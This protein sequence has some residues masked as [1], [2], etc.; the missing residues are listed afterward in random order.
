A[1]G[2][3]G[4]A[5][6][7][8][9][10]AR[11]YAMVDADSGGLYRS[12]DR[13]EHWVHASGDTRIWQRGWYFAGVTV[14]PENADVGY[15]CTPNLYRSADGGRTFAPIEG[16][17]TGDDFH[18]LWID[19]RRPERRILG[20]DQGAIVSVDGGRSWSSWYNQPTAQLYHVSTDE[21]FP[22]QVYGSQQ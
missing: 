12:D 6:A 9:E 2:R 1:P 22:Y 14:E 3:I 11:V 16:D 4:L 13:G 19:P 15:A 10:P 21:R 7:A 8:S 17:P 5:V 18:T 20:T